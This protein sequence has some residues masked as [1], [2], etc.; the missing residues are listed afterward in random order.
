MIGLV[1]KERMHSICHLKMKVSIMFWQNAQLK[2]TGNTPR[3]YNGLE[4]LGAPIR[5]IRIR[6]DKGCRRRIHGEEATEIHTSV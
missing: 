2:K 4:K 6:S 3:L 5:W 1:F